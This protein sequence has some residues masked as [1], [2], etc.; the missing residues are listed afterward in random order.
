[1]I[2]AVHC[3]LGLGLLAAMLWIA[4]VWLRPGTSTGVS[5][6]AV[7]FGALVY[8]ESLLN[9]S[10][11]STTSHGLFACAVALAAIWVWFK[12]KELREWAHI[13]ANVILGLATLSVVLG[14]AAMIRILTSI[15]TLHQIAVVALF[16]AAVWHAYEMRIYSIDQEDI[17]R[18]F[19]P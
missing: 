15:S 3:G 2:S 17:G 14:I 10:G 8:S 4:L 19:R 18:A 13:S 5:K 6:R 12:A 1:M 11:A 9:A 7:V 16:L